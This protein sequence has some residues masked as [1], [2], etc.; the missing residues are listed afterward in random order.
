MNRFSTHSETSSLDVGAETPRLGFVGVGWIGRNRMEAIARSG[1]AEITAI[2]D[3]SP[4]AMD[5]AGACA[6]AAALCPTFDELLERD[7][8][9]I[10]IATPS[11]LHAEQAI[12]A[13]QSGK[14][15]FCQKPL[16]RSA[17]ETKLV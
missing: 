8:D 15:V 7:L 16:A 6:P 13:L 10:V 14:A 17:A 1:F 12:A 2:S 5:K 3:P 9:G 11:A 4:E